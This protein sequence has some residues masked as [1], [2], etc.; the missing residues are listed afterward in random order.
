MLLLL[1]LWSAAESMTA[2]AA[3]HLSEQ[4]NLVTHW[5][6]IKPVTIDANDLGNYCA[7]VSPLPLSHRRLSPGGF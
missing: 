2:R 6:A 1:L 7:T 3:Q 4:I 5:L